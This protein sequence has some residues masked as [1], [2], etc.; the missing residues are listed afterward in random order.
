VIPTMILFG[1]VFGRWWRFALIAAAI[2]WPVLLLAT[3]VM[4]PGPGLLGA[5]G[6]AVANAGVGVIVHQV[7]LRAVRLLTRRMAGPA[8]A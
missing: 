7:A 3:G 8:G 4:K 2:A 1:L 6:L 5:S